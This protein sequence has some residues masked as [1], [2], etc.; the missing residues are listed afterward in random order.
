MPVTSARADDAEP[1]VLAYMIFSKEHRAKLHSINPIERLNGEIKR[2]TDVVGILPND[3]ASSDSSAPSCSALLRRT[4]R[5]RV[6]AW[7]RS[8]RYAADQVENPQAGGSLFVE[9]M[10]G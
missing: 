8:G 9:A 2:R 6:I 1:D 7:L 10:V 4:S 5:S 3:E